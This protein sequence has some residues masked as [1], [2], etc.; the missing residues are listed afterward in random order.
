MK[1]KQKETGIDKPTYMNSKLEEIYF[2]FLLLWRGFVEPEQFIGFPSPQS[3]VDLHVRRVE[4]TVEGSVLVPAPWEEVLLIQET[5]IYFLRGINTVR[6]TSYLTGLDLTKLVYLYLF[7]LKQ[8][9][10]ILT[11]QTGGH[12][13]GDT[14]PYKVSECS[15][16][17]C[18][19]AL[20]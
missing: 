12:S 4:T 2:S 20:E 18:S 8:S 17:Y 19:V 1:I 11:S 16:V 15:L 13:Y 9:S 6:L 14:S 3:P 10:W 7:R 5:L